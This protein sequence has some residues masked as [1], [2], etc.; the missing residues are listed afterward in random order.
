MNLRE[1]INVSYAVILSTFNEQEEAETFR[2]ELYAE[3]GTKA[4]PVSKGTEKLMAMM[5]AFKSPPPPPR[6]QEA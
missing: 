4:K 3:P 5:G 2:R 1:L 6:P